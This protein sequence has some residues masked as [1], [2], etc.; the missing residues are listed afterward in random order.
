MFRSLNAVAPLAL[1]AGLALA[2]ANVSAQ[3][4]DQVFLTRGAPRTGVVTD[5][6]GSA[7]PGVQVAR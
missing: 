2:A 4:T 5:A 1:V 7:L 3:T 6:S